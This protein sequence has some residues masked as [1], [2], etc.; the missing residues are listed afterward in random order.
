MIARTWY[1]YFFILPF[2]L[3]SWHK[4]FPIFLFYFDSICFN[5]QFFTSKPFAC[6]PST[7]PKYPPSKEIDARRRDEEI[8]RFVTFFEAHHWCIA[9][10]FLAIIHRKLQA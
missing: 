6:D 8:R 10:F 2:S 3:V 9:I 7:L 5:L 1:G 4:G